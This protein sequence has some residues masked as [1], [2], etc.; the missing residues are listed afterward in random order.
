MMS[1]RW[2]SRRSIIKYILVFIYSQSATKKFM[3]T[4]I[5]GCQCRVLQKTPVKLLIPKYFHLF[6]NLKFSPLEINRI[7]ESHTLRSSSVFVFSIH[8]FVSLICE[9]CNKHFVTDSEYLLLIFIVN[10]LNKELTYTLKNLLFIYQSRLNTFPTETS[11]LYV[12]LHF[13]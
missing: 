7:L 12:F 4:S 2:H 3:Q 11:L 13:S 8:W 1:P 10:K 5:K 6:Q 9:K